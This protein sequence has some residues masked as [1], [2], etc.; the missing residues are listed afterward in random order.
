M[1]SSRLY[2]LSFIAIMSI[3]VSCEQEPAPPVD[4]TKIEYS[5]PLIDIDGNSYKTVVID[6]LIWMAENLKVT[7][8]NDGVPLASISDS[9]QWQN[10]KLP[11]Y[12]WYNNDSI[13]NKPVF[14]ALYNYTAVQTGMLCPIGWHIPSL[15]EW[16]TL[17]DYAGGYKIAGGKLKQKGTELWVE[18]NIDA[19]D[20]FGFNAIPGGMRGFL[21]DAKYVSIADG[22]YWWCFEEENTFSAYSKEIGSYSAVVDNLSLLKRYGL[23]VRCIKN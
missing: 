19:T 7:K 15:E 10:T 18:P 3:I 4:K 14:G 8:F 1:I 11:A 22:A 16:N 17:I 13:N 5:D 12:C 20:E 9:H 23:S 21:Y 6:T 2:E